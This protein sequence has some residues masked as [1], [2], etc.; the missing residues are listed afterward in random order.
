MIAIKKKASYRDLSIIAGN[1]GKL[2]DE[3]ISLLNILSLIDE[4]P[5]KK[6]YKTL[7]K[8]MEKIIKEGGSLSD[9][10]KSGGRLIP[11]FFSSMIDIGERTGKIVY[12][13]KGLETFYDKLHCVR[14][15][16]ISAITYPLFLLAGLFL[17]G[18]FVVFFF[19]PSMSDIYLAMGK[20]IPILY[21][22]IITLKENFFNNPII[23]SIQLSILFVVLPYFVIK[24]FLRKYLDELAEKIPINNLIN[25]YISIVLMS[26]VI[27]SGINIAI[28][29]EY[30]CESEFGKGVNKTIKKIN[31]DITNGIMLSKSMS[32]IGMFSKYTLAHIKLGEESGS[33]DKRFQLLEEEVFKNLTIKINSLTQSIQPFLILF[34]GIVIVVFII[35]FILPL[36]DMVLM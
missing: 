33:L 1:I 31:N 28:G 4:L 11:S 14:K 8:E 18:I 2:Y 21:S 19:L 20:D 25:E 12:V 17:L 30:C 3:G 16:I 36:L 23:V 6:E 24:N 13:L 22:K 9:G 32:E 7:L 29:L 26:V 35:K 10:F 5:L 27:N 15:S 34:I